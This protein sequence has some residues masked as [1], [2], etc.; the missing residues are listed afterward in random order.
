MSGCL[1]PST[2]SKN[3]RNNIKYEI[4]VKELL[5]L[6]LNRYFLIGKNDLC[7]SL[8]TF[9]AQVY[10]LPRGKV[11]NSKQGIGAENVWRIWIELAY[12]RR[13]TFSVFVSKVCR[14]QDSD[15]M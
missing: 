7:F 11:N 5:L 13:R 15:Q 14:E 1:P 4:M 3:P 10:A 9:I 6:L 2:A 12:E 8:F